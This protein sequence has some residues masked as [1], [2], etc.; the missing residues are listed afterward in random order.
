M[1]NGQSLKEVMDNPEYLQILKN[2]HTFG[3][4]AAYRAYEKYNFY[5]TYFGCFDYLVNESHKEQFENLVLQDN[6]I[7][8]FYFIGDSK[9]KQNLF[10]SDVVS[11]PKFKNFNFKHIPLDKYNGISTNFENYYNPGSSGANALQI[12]IM[13]GYK[14]IILLGCDCNYTEEVNGVVHYDS[15]AVN[16]LELTKNLDYN[17]N[18][19]FSDYQQ[20]GD[21]FNLPNTDKF[22]MGSWK[23]ISKYCP[24]DVEIINCSMI[25][26]I[27]YFEKK[28]INKIKSFNIILICSDYKFYNSLL[29]LLNSI[30]DY[31]LSHDLIMIFDLGLTNEQIEFINKINL[32]LKI[33]NI[34]PILKEHDLQLNLNNVFVDITNYGF[35]PYVLRHFDKF[36]D[37]TLVVDAQEKNRDIN[38]LFIDS[39]FCINQSLEYIFEKINS[40]EFFCTDHNDCYK[41]ITFKNKIINSE[42]QGSI[43]NILPPS[44]YKIFKETNLNL[45][46]ENL[47]ENYIKAGLVGYKYFGKYQFIVNKNLEYFYKSKIYE[48]TDPIINIKEKTYYN[49]LFNDNNPLLGFSGD[50]RYDQTILSTLVILYKLKEDATKYSYIIGQKQG[51]ISF[52]IYNL[53]HIISN[54]EIQEKFN[55][56]SKNKE[57]EYSLNQLGEGFKIANYFGLK[58]QESEADIKR[59]IFSEN[60]IIWDHVKILNKKNLI[61]EIQ[62][63]NL[64]YYLLE[65]FI[66][67]SRNSKT[68]FTKDNC[69][70][71][72]EIEDIIKPISKT[73]ILHRGLMKFNYSIFNKIKNNS[74]KLFILGNGP[75]LKKIMDDPLKLEILKNN[76]TFGLN[77][78]YRV[79]DKYNFY[80]TYFGCFDYIVNESHKSNF[81]KLVLDDNTIKQF[82]F[83]GNAKNKQEL[84]S[85]EVRDSKKFTNLNFITRTPEEK[86]RNDIL[87]YDFYNFTDMLTSGTNSVQVGILKGYSEII[88]L[89]C[90]CNYKEVIEGAEIIDNRGK[91]VI[92]ENISKNPNYWFDEYQQKGDEFNVPNTNNCQLPAWNRLY[93]TIKSLKIDVKILNVNDNSKIECFDKIMIDEYFNNYIK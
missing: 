62:L 33:I 84:Y 45:S 14:K 60:D 86:L 69:L 93:N 76:H 36:L 57:I 48:L 25:S 4:N 22:Q 70:I 11:H 28:D 79:Y 46:K 89:G 73:F 18:Y 67:K 80:P 34:L 15:K 59:K 16:R 42:R 40:T 39:G 68:F 21:R 90:D 52:L 1:G 29:I 63:E 50:H 31:D 54:Y 85:K 3:L 23:N 74:K 12:G 27:P 6:G 75:S 72:F 66:E 71:Y 83:I 78:A 24:K 19:W 91:I 61:S 87:A 17:P 10:K 82:F 65:K 32:N 64:Y 88:L 8:E 56:L 77:A 5:P 47:K 53:K 2:N 30:I 35:K 7:K 49:N 13:K 92:K 41:I 9:N 58:S 51:I 43:C 81:E 38:V 55:S 37:K 44:V 20:K 26:K